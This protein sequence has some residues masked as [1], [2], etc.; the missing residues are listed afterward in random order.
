MSGWKVVLLTPGRKVTSS[1]RASPR[2][3]VM[4]WGAAAMGVRGMR[5]VGMV[6]ATARARRKLCLVAGTAAAGRADAATVR[7][8]GLL[9]GT[10]FAKLKFKLKKK[11]DSE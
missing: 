10:E 2:V 3:M 9:R 4:M 1:V 5:Q 7:T 6:S 8:E 11:N